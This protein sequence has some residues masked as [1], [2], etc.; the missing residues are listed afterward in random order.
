MNLSKR[1]KTIADM[2]PDESHV[3]DVGCDHGL[4]SIYLVKEKKCT[5]VATDINEK[6]L[7]NAKTNIKKYKIQNIET[8]LTDGLDNIDINDDDYIVLAGMGTTTIKHILENK[9]LSSNLI[10]SSNNQLKELR[11][12]MISIG[13]L[14]IDEKFVVDHQK[15]Y[16]IIKFQKGHKKYSKIDLKYGP[17]VRH[18][19]EYL[20]YELAK[21]FEIKEKIKDSHFLVR[22]NNQ[23]EI[24]KLSSLIRKEKGK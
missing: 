5:S 7:N 23:K 6:A 8:K 4:L 14:I 11:C 13:Y 18:D 19:T 21:L 17:I 3:I 16:V 10:I 20:I 12:F 15:K 9:K 24:N 2:I 1:L 22:F